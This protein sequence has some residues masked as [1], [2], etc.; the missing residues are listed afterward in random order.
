MTHLDL[1]VIAHNL[2]HPFQGLFALGLGAAVS[3]KVCEAIELLVANQA[4]ECRH[5]DRCYQYPCREVQMRN[6]LLS[7]NND[8]EIASLRKVY[9]D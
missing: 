4:F 5:H 6:K 1:L 8:A 9:E 2:N 3:D 7:T